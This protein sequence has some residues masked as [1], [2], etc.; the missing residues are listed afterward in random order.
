MVDMTLREVTV[1]VSIAAPVADAWA[2]VT[3]W[4]RQG[5]WMLGTRVG[6]VQG[7]GRSVGSRLFGFTGVWDVGFLDVLEIVEWEPPSRCRAVHLGKLLRGSAEF[8][9]SA[10]GAGAIVSW[11][12]R[13]E[14]PVGLAAPLLGWGMRRS[15]RRLAG[16]WG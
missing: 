14:P 15:L 16:W 10:R 13:L 8:A 1:R 2:A 7:D 6:V 4:S 11:T 3:D 9:V 5:E 12:E